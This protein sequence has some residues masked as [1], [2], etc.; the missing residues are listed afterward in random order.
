[1]TVSDISTGFATLNSNLNSFKVFDIA[2]DRVNNM[3]LLVRDMTTGLHYIYFLDGALLATTGT[4]TIQP[5]WKMIDSQGTDV[6][7]KG[8]YYS[9]SGQPFDAYN[10]YECD[11]L[12][13]DNNGNLVV[14][15]DKTQIGYSTTGLM[16][17]TG[18]YLYEYKYDQQATEPT[19]NARLYNYTQN[20]TSSPVSFI[21]DAATNIYPAFIPLTYQSVSATYNSN[22]ELNVNWVTDAEKDNKYFEIQ[23]ST[24]G[25]NFKPIGSINTKAYLGNST[26]SITYSFSKSLQGISFSFIPFLLLT[27]LSGAF[28]K[29]N[30]L[31]Y[32]VIIVVL[33]I[34][35]SCSKNNNGEAPPVQYNKVYVRIMHVDTA[36]KQSF[37]KIVLAVKQ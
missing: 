19:L 22:N 27:L 34:A 18:N 11:G 36:D 3:Y 21:Q 17:H 20:R 26:K 2:F 30:R 33:L 10:T 37:S 12:A 23:A 29:A 16:L 7:F 25:V 28:S 15:V 5:K 4:I 9:W 24:D 35:I 31:K 32:F 6:K 1:G 13:F 14:G 8:D